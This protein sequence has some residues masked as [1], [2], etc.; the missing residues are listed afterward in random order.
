MTYLEDLIDPFKREVSIPGMFA[1]D[2]PSATDDDLEAALGDAFA[3]AQLEGWF[4]TFR[5]DV[6]ALQITPQLS[7]AG[8]ALVVLYAGIRMVRQKLRTLAVNRRYKA[9]SVEVE[10]SVPVNVLLAELKDLQGR[11]NNIVEQTKL[12]NQPTPVYMINGY[13]ARLNSYGGF[14][15]G[16]LPS[17]QFLPTTERGRQL[18][19][20]GGL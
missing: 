6:D 18:S 20:Y 14:A 2:F 3:L 5:L 13:V 7:N 4:P 1:T 11:L 17:R 19:V 8:A 12:T 16:E 15:S 9:G 10:T